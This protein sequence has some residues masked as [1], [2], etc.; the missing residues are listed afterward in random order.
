MELEESRNRYY[1]LYDFAPIG[2]FTFD[3]NGLIRE[4]NLTGTDQ[5]GIER[6]HLMKRGFSLFVAPDFQD[7]FSF[8]YKRALKTRTKQ[9]CELRLLKKDGTPF[10]AQLESIAVQDSE[11]NFSQLRTAITDITDR[12]RAEEKLKEYSEQLEDMVEQRAPKNSERPRRS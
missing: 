6:S 10:Y 12:K 7:V 5:L 8:H 2:Y 4:V 11:G 1:D 3:R 9:T